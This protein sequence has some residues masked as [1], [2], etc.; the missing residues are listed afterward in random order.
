MAVYGV[1]V[2]AEAQT[3]NAL[4]KKVGSSLTLLSQSQT[5]VAASGLTGAEGTPLNTIN[6]NLLASPLDLQQGLTFSDS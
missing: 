1:Y 4:T 5:P 3:R 6:P 2:I